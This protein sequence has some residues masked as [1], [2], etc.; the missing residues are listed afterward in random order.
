MLHKARLFA[1]YKSCC[2]EKSFF[3]MVR[4]KK[5][6]ANYNFSERPVR[7]NADFHNWQRLP[8]CIV[9]YT[10]FKVR[11]FFYLKKRWK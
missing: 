10:L 11:Y 6:S 1:N 5:N 4:I 8:F 2:V 9:F 7:L 3:K